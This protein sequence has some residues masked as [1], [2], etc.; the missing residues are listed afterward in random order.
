MRY[1]EK[2]FGMLNRDM[3]KRDLFFYMAIVVM[4]D[5][6]VITK[7][8]GSEAMRNSRT[9]AIVL[10]AV[11][12]VAI[13][14]YIIITKPRR[15]IPDALIDAV[16]E[17]EMFLPDDITAREARDFLPD[18]SK[19]TTY[20]CRKGDPGFDVVR[21]TLRNLK[22]ARTTIQPDYPRLNIVVRTADDQMLIETFHE[23]I[24]FGGTIYRVRQKDLDSLFFNEKFAGLFTEK[25]IL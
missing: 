2:S 24:T 10:T 6:Y 4:F 18:F 8:D 3:L 1:N 16:E 22:G 20:M 11:L 15:L 17:F 5:I 7:Y 14:L 21:D 12:V 13:A 19:D 25:I 9:I 23:N